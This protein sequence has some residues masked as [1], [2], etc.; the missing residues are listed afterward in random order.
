MS[1]PA[2]E[3]YDV[4]V[5]DGAQK[6]LR[7]GIG[8]P[9][10]LFGVD[11]D[12]DAMNA[13][14]KHE[15][16][17]RLSTPRDA[18]EGPHGWTGAWLRITKTTEKRVLKG[19]ADAFHTLEVWT[20]HIGQEEHPEDNTSLSGAAR[21]VMRMGRQIQL[22]LESKLPVEVPSV[23]YIK[24]ADNTNRVPQQPD[25]KAPS[26]RVLVE[27]YNVTQRV[28]SAFGGGCE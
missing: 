21:D 13:V 8:Q 3:V 28:F 6:I 24:R 18:A 22:L 5:I 17:A 20:F 12:I 2:P 4:D 23:R 15:I 16:A 10:R 25:K 27:T 7:D 11:Y 14:F 26:A 19:A 1:I 9:V